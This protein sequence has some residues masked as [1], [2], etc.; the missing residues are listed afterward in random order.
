MDLFEQ[1]IL[2]LIEDEKERKLWELYLHS[3]MGKSFNEWKKDVEVHQEQDKEMTDEE[4]NT[5]VEKAQRA[6][7]LKKG[8]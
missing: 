4:I 8:G 3:H 6:L 1:G 5:A 2:N 7:N